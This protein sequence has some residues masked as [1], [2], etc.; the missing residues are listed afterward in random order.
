M[1]TTSENNRPEA[2]A[3][4]HTPPLLQMS[5]ETSV[6]AAAGSLQTKSQRS[7]NVDVQPCLNP[8]Y[9][10]YSITKEKV[11]INVFDKRRQI[12]RMVMWAIVFAITLSMA[13]T[14]PETAFVLYLLALLSLCA[15]SY[16]YIQS[17][18]KAVFDLV[19][20]K[21]HVP[22]YISTRNF[23]G[24]EISG[25]QKVRAPAK[26]DYYLLFLKK[27]PNGQGYQIMPR[28]SGLLKNRNKDVSEFEAKILPVINQI[29]Y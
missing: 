11:E 3:T 16:A 17:R 1:V 20:R 10:K 8:Y 15:L 19:N 24:H 21:A 7:C 5:S 2:I 27:D 6:I 13:L 9:M 4:R 12:F 14:M 28:Y 25:F 26:S 29:I 22:K 23:D 18:Q